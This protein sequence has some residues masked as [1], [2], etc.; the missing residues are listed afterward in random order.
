[1]DASRFVGTEPLPAGS[2][3]NPEALQ[4]YLEERLE[5]CRGEMTIERFRGGQSNPTMVLSFDGR[6]RL[7]LRK[8]PDGKL[9]PSA[10]AVDRE[11]RVIS[12]LHHSAVPVAKARLLCEDD[13]I[14]GAMFYIMDYVEGRSF[15]DPTLPNMTPSERNAIYAEMNRIIVTLHGID[16]TQAGLENFGKPGDYVSRQVARWTK[17]Y[18]ASETETIEAMDQL[19]EWLP[20]HVPTQQRTSLI[21]GDFRIDNMIFHPTDP[22]V[23]A[24][25]DW[26]L[27]TLG[28]PMA[29]FAYHML[30]WHFP[31]QPYR[32]LSGVDLGALGIP[33][34]RAYRDMYLARTGQPNISDQDW[35]AYLAYCLFRVAGIRQGIMKRVVEGTA[36]SPHAREAGALARPVA[37]LGWYYAETAMK[38]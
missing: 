9:L 12:A 28:D 24:V 8:K 35:Y 29:D 7:V 27:S 1:M 3:L 4:R 26:E 23:L 33:D 30:T 32:G 15:W 2:R 6:R 22:S 34:E 11:Y 38:L 19:I 31:Q 36:S 13:E 20:Q 14:A 37:D 17:Q 5:G 16:Y 18:R 10:H 21:H 25:V